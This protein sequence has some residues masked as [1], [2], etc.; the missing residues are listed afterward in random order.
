MCFQRNFIA[1]DRSRELIGSV[2][3]SNCKELAQQPDID[4]FLVG[5]L[6]KKEA[7]NIILLEFFS[8]GASLKPEFEQICK[9]R[10][11]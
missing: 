1:F 9:S 6:N 3:G 8:L 4:G 5:G 7:N 10:Q 11:N 2:S